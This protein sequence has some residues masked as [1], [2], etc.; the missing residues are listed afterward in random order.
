V[1]FLT[2]LM[3]R[4]VVRLRF[5][6]QKNCSANFLAKVRALWPSSELAEEV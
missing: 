2:I 5:T 3:I 4:K 1:R 6:T